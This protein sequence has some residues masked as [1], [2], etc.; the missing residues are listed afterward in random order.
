MISNIIFPG[1]AIP[2]DCYRPCTGLCGNTI[3]DGIFDYGFFSEDEAFEFDKFTLQGIGDCVLSA[4][5]MGALLAMEAAAS[6][7]GIK[8][9]ILF[10]PFARFCSAH[11]CPGQSEENVLKMIEQ[12]EISPERLLKSFYRTLVR[13]SHFKID[14]PEFLN[15]NALREGLEFLLRSDCRDL[16]KNIK[17]PVLI[18]LGGRDEITPLITGEYLAEKLRDV[19]LHVFEGAG[20][21]LPFTNTEEC[22]L[23]IRNFLDEKNLI[24]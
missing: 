16:L 10:S 5:S 14:V 19:T 4:H 24:A 3:S 8:A 15:K 18:M 7:D 6:S 20:H 21:A 17:I 23:K 12:L 2:P 1:W 13:P 22:R 9:L 11:G